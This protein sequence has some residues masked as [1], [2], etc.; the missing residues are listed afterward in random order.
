MLIKFINYLQYLLEKY[1]TKKRLPVEK[2]RAV[3]LDTSAKEN[4]DGLINL[5]FYYMLICHRTGLHYKFQES[6][7]DN[8]NIVRSLEFFHFLEFSHIDY[9]NYEN[10]V[11]M[12][13][14]TVVNYEF[15]NGKEAPILTQKE[16]V[17]PP[18]KY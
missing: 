8:I 4:T 3:L 16:L 14:D 9:E 6:I 1:K 15:I 13:F 2:Y 18:P 17:A 10:L 11:G 12:V 7:V 5:T